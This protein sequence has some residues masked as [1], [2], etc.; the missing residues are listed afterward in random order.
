MPKGKIA[1]ITAKL[2]LDVTGVSTALAEI[3][4]QSRSLASEMRA[5]DKAMEL[6]PDSV[7]IAAQKQ[8]ILAKQIDVT[9]QKLKELTSVQ[10]KAENAFKNQD[11]WQKEYE[12]LKKSIDETTE[13]LKKLQSVSKKMDEEFASGKISADKYKAYSD[14]LEATKQK[15]AELI[16]SEK[17]LEDKFKDGHITAEEYRAFQRE[18]ETTKKKLADLEK[19]NSKTGDSAKKMGADIQDSSVNIKNAA[20]DVKSYEDAVSDLNSAI[21]NVKNDLDGI[22]AAAG[23]AVAGIGTAAVGAVGKAAEVGMDFEKSMSKVQAISGATA[24]DLARLEEA[25]KK[26]GATTSKTA[27][28]SAD[29]LGYM[30]LAGWNTEQMLTGLEPILRASEAGQIDLARTSDLVTDSMS[31]M[32]VEVSGLGHYLDVVAKAQSNSNTSMEQLLE[33]FVAVGGTA[34][35]LGIDVE[36]LST[37]LGVMANRGIKGSEAGNALNAVLVNM[38]GS[39]S[40]T[41]E[42]MSALGLS[43]FD[44]EGNTKNMTAVLKDMGAALSVCTD[45]QKT[46][47]EAQLGGKTQMDALQAIINGVGSEYDSLSES[48][49]NADG[50]L[51]ETAKTM[52]DNL[53]GQIT[54]MQS[55]LE[56]LGIDVYSYLEEPFKGAVANVTKEIQN[57]SQSVTGGQLSDTLSRLSEALGKLLESAGEFA[58]NEGIPALINTLDWISRNGDKIEAVILGMGTAWTSW[59][60]GTLVSH[61][62]SLVK[63][64]KD[65]KVAQEAATAAQIAANK[66]AMANVYVAVAAAVSALTVALGKLW[67]SA[68]DNAAA[69]LRERNALDDTTKALIEKENAVKDNIS[70]YSELNATAD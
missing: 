30:A 44:E 49:R 69:N 19:T 2:G 61:V 8:E 48:L 47:L 41:A 33:A 40:R 21:G 65:F 5:V 60:I 15:M 52:Q 46:L 38:L 59:K 34:H 12:P 18:V 36:K 42:A 39:T 37:I 17:E 58:V 29:A 10:K 6:N 70:A 28:E 43:M 56:G 35:N 54:E 24:D 13:K 25:S 27:S 68:I 14:E 45:E 62:V 3:D 11:K 55:A 67:A 7:V 1:G 26:M 22:A 53:A 31:A 20:K 51:T 16:K 23:A 63:A 57:L 64:I 32:G 4:K 9:S 66:A 50:A